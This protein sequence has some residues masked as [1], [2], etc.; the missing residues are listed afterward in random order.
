MTTNYYR[1]SVDLIAF[2][3]EIVKIPNSNSYN[4]Y[5][6]YDRRFE[7]EEF[8]RL[9]TIRF[10]TNNF[11]VTGEGS[12]NGVFSSN[13]SAYNHWANGTLKFTVT[14]KNT[15]EIGAFK[16]VSSFEYGGSTI[17]SQYF[18]SIVR[19]NIKTEA[20]PIVL[21]DKGENTFEYTISNKKLVSLSIKKTDENGTKTLDG[22]KFKLT[23]PNDY[24]KELTTADGGLA[25]FDNLAPGEYTLTEIKAPEGYAKVE[26]S[27]KIVIAED[28]PATITEPVTENTKTIYTLDSPKTGMIQ[29]SVWNSYYGRYDYYDFLNITNTLSQIDN[30]NSFKLKVDYQGQLNNTTVYDFL[31]TFNTTDFDV[32]WNGQKVTANLGEKFA[33]NKSGSYEFIVTLKNP[34]N[35]V[36]LSPITSVTYGGYGMPST[37]LPSITPKVVEV[38]PQI[39]TLT[40]TADNTFEY[41]IA[42]DLA[43]YEVEF[44]KIAR[45][46]PNDTSMDRP[47]SKVEFSIFKKDSET[48]DFIDTE[49]KV[50][51]DENGLIS[52][53]ELEPG[54]YE[55]HEVSAPEG[56]RLIEGSAKSFKIEKDGSTLI[57]DKSGEYIPYDSGVGSE[58][59]KIINLKSGT[60][61]FSL[62]KK[63]ESDKALEGVEFELRNSN[64]DIVAKKSTDKDGKITFDK[65]PYGKYWL[66]ETKTLDGYILDSKPIPIFIGED[67]E[68]PEN[69]ENS[70]D[71]SE[72]IKVNPDKESSLV[73]TE[74]DSEVVYPNKAE[75]IMARVHF[76]FDNGIEVKPG[77]TFTITL[78]DNLD[79]DGI[80]REVDE[81]FDIMASSG[82]LAKAKINDDRRSITYTITEY[83]DH[84]KLNGFLINTPMFV[85]RMAI[86][87]NTDDVEFSI[88]IGKSVFKDTINVNYEPYVS[89]KVAVK[90]YVTKFDPDTGDF[91]TLI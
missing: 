41:S 11:T 20:D 66:K 17:G 19:E 42:N 34:Q 84:Y 4:F 21:E 15:Q 86:K 37:G 18:A 32:V 51:S 13:F 80:G 50:I 56:Y 72:F 29:Y 49:K 5:I 31:I 14:P 16:P 2:K 47:L 7:Y 57:K 39:K 91:T 23:G 75:G 70:K 60:E 12:T 36:K 26:G 67:W 87:N 69:T 44:L 85:N 46:N 35:G 62:T 58:E 68:V 33:P 61:K 22:A 10:D 6:H 43:K 40:K 74:D 88:G 45:D 52:I 77:D 81:H 54:E 79:L 28:G 83:A 90:S 71:I 65:L 78:S 9:L 59:K 53:K 30:S 3:Q 1:N 64:G 24:S 25:L 73:S 38:S 48:E 89:E 55:L 76:V 27:W 82:K 8:I 63:D